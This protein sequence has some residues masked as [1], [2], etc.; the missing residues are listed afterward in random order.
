M[1][2][3]KLI[4]N[5]ERPVAKIDFITL[6]LPPA[7][8]TVGDARRFSANVEGR[9]AAPK[10]WRGSKDDRLTIHDP[11]CADLQFLIDEHHE[12]EILALEVAVDFSLKD[13]SND[14]ARLRALHSWLKGSLFPQRHARMHR[15]GRRK[16]YDVADGT[17]KADT[18][19]TRSGDESV[20]WANASGFELVR[21]YIKTIDNKRPVSRHSVRLEV[22]L[23]RGGCQLARVHR[24]GLLPVFANDLRRYLSPFFNVAAGI[25]PKLKRTRSKDPV[26][27]RES[28]RLAEKERIGVERNWL[29]YGAAWA[30]QHGHRVVPD[31]KTNRL[32][33]VALKG[34]RERLTALEAPRK[35][36][37]WRGWVEVQGLMYEGVG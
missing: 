28:E 11:S 10:S 33:G 4:E 30:S 20:Y 13:D 7:I 9:I 31:V 15:T 6:G 19:Q 14:P 18:L 36:A 5:F 12:A 29:R 17:I 32:V 22:N 24:V 25:K 16:Y 34:L 1:D 37:G 23:G 8:R 21:L 2:Y 35:V 26:R 27:V 3:A